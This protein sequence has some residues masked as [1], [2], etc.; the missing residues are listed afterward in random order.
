M[1]GTQ[2]PTSDTMLYIHNVNAM[3]NLKTAWFNV[4]NHT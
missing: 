4:N 1:G 3:L 2:Y